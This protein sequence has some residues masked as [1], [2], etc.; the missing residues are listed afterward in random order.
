MIIKAMSAFSSFRGQRELTHGDYLFIGQQLL[1]VEQ[2][3]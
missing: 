1:R 3:A 2:T